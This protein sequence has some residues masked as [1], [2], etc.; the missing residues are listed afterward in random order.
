M[1][2]QAWVFASVSKVYIVLP[3]VHSIDGK[4]ADMYFDIFVNAASQINGG[5]P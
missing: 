1:Y 2:N 5:G 3:P 4:D